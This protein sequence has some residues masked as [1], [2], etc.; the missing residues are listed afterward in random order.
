MKRILEMAN[1]N[2]CG[3]NR[4]EKKIQLYKRQYYCIGSCGIKIIKPKELI[5]H[6]YVYYQ[7]EN[8]SRSAAFWLKKIYRPHLYE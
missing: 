6:G 5:Y 2:H 8:K 4:K 3:K 1:C 7:W